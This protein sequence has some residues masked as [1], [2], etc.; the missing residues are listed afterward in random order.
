[1]KLTRSQLIVVIVLGVLVVGVYGCLVGTV[2]VNSRQISQITASAAATSSPSAAATG[3]LAPSPTATASP[4][5][6]PT[7]LPAA[8]QTRYDLQVKRDPE[9]PTLRLQRGYAYIELEAEYYAVEDFTTAIGL[10]ATLFEAYLGR[11]IARFYL[12]EWSA[13]LEDFEQALALNPDLADAHVWRG[14]LLYL[15]GEYEPALEA[16]RQAIALDEADPAKHIMLAEAL[17]DSGIP[18]EAEEEYA[19]AL[20]LDAR[21]VEAY[22]GRAMARAEQRNLDGAM[23]DLSSAQEISPYDPVVLNG[24]AWFYA[25]YQH[26]H[27]DEAEQ[28]AQRA[29]DGTKDDLD[30]AS[31]LDTLGWVYYEQGRYEEAVAALE[32][33]AAL[34]TVEGEVICSDIVEHLEEA[35]AAQ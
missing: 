32:E 18:E 13:A 26:D 34:A 17:L 20:S 28:L 21:S 9:N 25:W 4:T 31:C 5:P 3:E 27:L 2:V 23:A 19:A 11:G 14:Y 12:K 30:R 35:R 8:P 15:R 22:V 7:P 1:M 29:V 10:D 24:Q 6:T 16:L 33:A